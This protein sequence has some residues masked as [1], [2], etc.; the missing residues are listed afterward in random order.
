MN[1]CMYLHVLGLC[2]VCRP[3]TRHG[4][5][6]WIFFV[7]CPF[8][9]GSRHGTSFLHYS[10]YKVRTD[11]L[12]SRL[13][14]GHVFMEDRLEVL[15]DIPREARSTDSD[16]KAQ[17]IWPLHVLSNASLGESRRKQQSMMDSTYSY[18]TPYYFDLHHRRLYCDRRG[19]PEPWTCWRNALEP[20]LQCTITI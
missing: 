3:N 20:V 19:F 17:V 5:C 16:G 15:V 7:L 8:H 18:P 2:R 6:L 12:L 10:K 9:D 1:C 4:K 11:D 14:K 13:E